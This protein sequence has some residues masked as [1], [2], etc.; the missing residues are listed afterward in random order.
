M[1]SLR[2]CTS[3]LPPLGAQAASVSI[4]PCAS[5]SMG[6]AWPPPQLAYSSRIAGC[7]KASSSAVEAWLGLGLGLGLGSGL[8][9]GLG[10]GFG[11]ANPNPD[12]P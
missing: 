9:L 6:V 1:A 4:M 2:P 3:V 12:Q 11:L 5:L 7:T 10:L 8:G